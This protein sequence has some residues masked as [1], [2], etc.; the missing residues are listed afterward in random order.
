MAAEVYED[1]L[2][3]TVPILEAVLPDSGQYLASAYPY[4]SLKLTGRQEVRRFR[5][6]VLEN[7]YL[8]VT[9]VPD[10]GGRILRLLDKRTNTEIFPDEPLTPVEGGLR[11]VEISQG[12]QIR[13]TPQDRHNSLGTVNYQ[14]VHPDDEEDDA[15]VWI[16]E[17][18]V[19]LSFN[20]L[21]SLPPDAAEIDIE[22]RMFN[23]IIGD[24]IYNAGLH[25]GI[26]NPVAGY[27][28]E[29][30]VS[31]DFGFV[32]CSASTR[33]GLFVETDIGWQAAPFHDARGLAV[34]RF[35]I[36]TDF[37]LSA[38]QLDAWKFNIR[39]ISGLDG[40]ISAFDNGAVGIGRDAF[41]VLL[42]RQISQSRIYITLKNG[43][44]FDAPV[45]ARPDVIARL[46]FN[47][48]ED[49]EKYEVRTQHGVKLLE[50]FGRDLVP[51]DA[52][53]RDHFDRA[54]E[55]DA[56]AR[57][58]MRKQLT[59]RGDIPHALTSLR[60]ESY[61]PDFIDA[62]TARFEDQLEQALIYN[63]ED[64]LAWWAKAVTKRLKGAKDQ[65]PAEILNA[66]Y[67]A[68]LEPALRGESFLSQPAAQ[69]REPNPILK[70]LQ[71]T[72]D[73]LIEIACLLTE[74]RL[75]SEAS[76]FLDEALRH[77]D[78]SMLHYLQA[79]AL[80]MGT[81]MDVEVV[82]H[83]QAAGSKPFSPPFPYRFHELA[84]L[85]GLA[86]NYEPDE[87]LKEYLSV[88]RRFVSDGRV[89]TSGH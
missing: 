18:G 75:F 8:R 47:Q 49:I 20:A 13:Y 22:L 26:P 66:H 5:T 38:R 6:V 31:P 84:A 42:H 19:G 67:L 2:E 40:Q 58:E 15:G 64:H 55:I 24:T 23:R 52:C 70:P 28:E 17:V 36:G 30:S 62:S 61:F 7:P 76:R 46:P 85:D 73:Q 53:D 44:K 16:G 35:G 43:E 82:S 81:R 54:A 29:P 56:R 74:L 10:L 59:D 78:I 37:S 27:S 86:H 68:P 57:R 87:R 79:H 65:A 63:G 41:Y 72:P 51:F 33:S 45:D 32:V 60:Y 12:I 83:L 48:M 80:M 77:V 14:L 34:H 89:P 9:I 11:G 21:I 39:P 71:E 1:E 3:L 88:A 25:I 4:P 50:F 69:G